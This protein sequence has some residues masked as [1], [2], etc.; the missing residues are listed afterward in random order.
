MTK[1]EFKN[2]TFEVSTQYDGIITVPISELY[3]DED[4]DELFG[5]EYEMEDWTL[6]DDALNLVLDSADLDLY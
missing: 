4:I 2:K 1:E 6:M 3:T 5:M